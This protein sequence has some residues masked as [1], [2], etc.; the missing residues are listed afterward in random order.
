MKDIYHEL[1]GKQ[2]PCELVDI[3][4][5]EF[6]GA[7]YEDHTRVPAD[8]SKLG[9]LDWAPQHGLRETFTQIIGWYLNQH[10]AAAQSAA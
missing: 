8:I 6:Y 7:G 2:S 1:T 3:D 5:T 9:S 4:G 10:S